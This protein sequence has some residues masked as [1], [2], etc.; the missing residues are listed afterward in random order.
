MFI[1]QF[2]RNLPGVEWVESFLKRNTQLSVR[3]ASSIKITRVEVDT[4]T[5]KSFFDNITPELT[6][7]SYI[8]HLQLR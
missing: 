5:I 4:V 6:R 1:R 3:F 8:K 7:G 2:L